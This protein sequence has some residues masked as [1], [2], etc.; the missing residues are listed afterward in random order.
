MFKFEYDINIRYKIKLF[1]KFDMKVEFLLKI[2]QTLISL[3]LSYFIIIK[4]S[5][6]CLHVTT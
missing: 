4:L 2:G 6:L 5:L 1:A 3:N